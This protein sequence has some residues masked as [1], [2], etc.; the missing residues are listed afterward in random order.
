M[1]RGPETAQQRHK[2]GHLAHE[3]VN[4]ATCAKKNQYEHYDEV[5]NVLTHAFSVATVGI[6]VWFAS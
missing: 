5:E 6:L 4:K 1:V 2:T 3:T